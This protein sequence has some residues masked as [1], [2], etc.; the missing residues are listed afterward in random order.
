MLFCP[1]QR[2]L[3]EEQ[4]NK[5]ITGK[6]LSYQEE[7]VLRSKV[8]LNH[9]NDIVSQTIEASQNTALIAW[10]KIRGNPLFAGR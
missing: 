7:Q 6:G 4:F 5:L 3:T 1:E 10:Q 9:D 2:K 8:G